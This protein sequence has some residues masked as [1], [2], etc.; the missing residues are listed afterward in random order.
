MALNDIKEITVTVNGTNKAVKQ[1]EDS[2]GNIIWGSQSA[3]PYRRLEYIESDGVNYI[4]TGTRVS[5]TAIYTFQLAFGSN[6]Q[7]NALSGSETSNAASNNA[8]FKFG[9]NSSGNLYMGFGANVTSSTTPTVNEFYTFY[10]SPGNQYIKDSNGNT[11]ISGSNTL[12]SSGLN[13]GNITIFA[14]RMGTSPTYISNNIQTKIKSYIVVSNNVAY[15]YIPV[16]RKSDGKC[17]LYNSTANTFY[18]ET[19]NGAL[20]PGPVVD[21]YWDLTA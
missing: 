3:F 21:E 18:P 13:S 1:I 16:Q 2:N 8:R 19:G 11:I 7:G 17:G 9:K 14:L 6:T 12:P 4:D 20:I 5:R 10:A 15:P